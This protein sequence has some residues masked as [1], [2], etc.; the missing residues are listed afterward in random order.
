MKQ[1]ASSKRHEIPKVDDVNFIQKNN[2]F[3]KGYSVN[4][5]HGMAK[6]YN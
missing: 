5:F 2:G 4:T 3:V 6:N 1:S